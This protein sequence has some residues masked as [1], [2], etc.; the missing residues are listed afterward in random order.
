MSVRLRVFCE[1][2]DDFWLDFPEGD[3]SLA[4]PFV[5][6]GRARVKN[7]DVGSINGMSVVRKLLNHFDTMFIVLLNELRVTGFSMIFPLNSAMVS[8]QM[9]R[10]HSTF[11]SLKRFRRSSTL[12][13]QVS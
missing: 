11:S 7:H 4:D 3:V 12:P 9:R 8:P 13:L 10:S 6:Y 2:L 5:F 1:L